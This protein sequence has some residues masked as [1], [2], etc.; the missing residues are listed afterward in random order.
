M[1]CYLRHMK[2]VLD[3]AGIVI[4]KAN[5]KQIDRAIH[6]AVDVA[7]K[8]CPDTWKEIKSNIMDDDEKRRVFIEQLKAVVD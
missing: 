8:N 6:Q 2:A 1:S 3:E 4:T 7:Y 5:R